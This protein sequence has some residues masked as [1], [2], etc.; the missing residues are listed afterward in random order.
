MSVICGSMV[1]VHYQDVGDAKG[2]TKGDTKHCAITGNNHS[3][4]ES[5]LGSTQQ[6][7]GVAMIGV[8]D[9]IFIGRK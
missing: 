5:V 2:D 4:I 8:Y 7:I 6:S 1:P 3:L 9:N